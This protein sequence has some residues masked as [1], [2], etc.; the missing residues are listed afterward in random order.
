MTL[1]GSATNGT[2][3]AVRNAGERVTNDDGKSEAD[4][5]DARL[6]VEEGLEGA[7]AA[8]V[9]P[10][11]AQLGYRLVRV[12]ISQLNGMTLQIMAERADGTMAVED[13][14][15][16]SR[17]V[18]PVLD[19]EDP[20]EQ[21]YHLEVSSPG[22]DRPLVRHADFATWTHHLIKLET[23]RLVSG[24]KRFRGKIVEV[25]RDAIR[26]ERDQA[27]PEE[28]LVVEIALDAITDARLILTDELIDA[29]LKADKA[30]R[31]GHGEND[32]DPA[33]GQDQ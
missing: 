22:I 12:R 7:I 28:E 32:N 3:T 19:V 8:I 30:A 14:E 29:A 33:T 10:V 5:A 23:S 2:A 21:E 25:L 16:V 15:A 18:S 26:F 31:K 24:R 4:A 13:C 27:H 20:I 9:E 17:A 1:C 11:I 6:I